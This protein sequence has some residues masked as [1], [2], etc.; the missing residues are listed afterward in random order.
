[1][2]LIMYQCDSNIDIVKYFVGQCQLIL[3]IKY[4]CERLKLF[5]TLK[6]ALCYEMN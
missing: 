6:M 5:Y 3:P 2:F 4:H 1:M